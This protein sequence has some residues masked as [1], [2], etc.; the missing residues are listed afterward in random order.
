MDTTNFSESYQSSRFRYSLGRPSIR[1]LLTQLEASSGF[2]PNWLPVVDGTPN[3]LV[4]IRVLSLMIPSGVRQI[5]QIAGANVAGQRP[6]RR[7]G[8]APFASEMLTLTGSSS[9]PD[10]SRK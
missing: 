4:R 7:C 10:D 8:F 6:F 9:A 3:F 5:S 2:D 1:P